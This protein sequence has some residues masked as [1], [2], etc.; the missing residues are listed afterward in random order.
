MTLHQ[1]Y[2]DSLGLLTDLYQLTMAQGYWQAGLADREAV[3]H[4]T[5][6]HCPFGGQYAV[7][8]GLKPA[9]EYVRDFAFTDEDVAY[10]ATLPDNRDK[11][12]FDPRFLDYLRQLRF[13]GDVHAMPE[14]TLAFPREPLVRVQAPL[15]QAQLLETPLLTLINFPTLVATKAARICGEAAGQSVLEFGLRRAQGP[16]GGVSASRAAYIGGCGATSN[17][18]AGK[19]FGIPVK[20]THAHSWVMAFDDELAA[21]EAYADAMP[22]KGIFLVDTYETRRSLLAAARSAQ[23]RL[24]FDED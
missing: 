13:R 23:G 9:L 17:V 16:D 15:L 20:G 14:G 11:P 18:L 10:L 12:L 1:L 22:N 8:C 21:F 2:R 7:A 24:F 19:L 4:L 6:R 5:F 3:F